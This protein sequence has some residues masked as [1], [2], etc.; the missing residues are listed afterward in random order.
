M[1]DFLDEHIEEIIKNEP[2]IDEIIRKEMEKE[3]EKDKHYFRIIAVRVLGACAPRIRRALKEETT[4]FLCNDYEDKYD[5]TGKWQTIVKITEDGRLPMDFFAIPK[6][7]KRFCSPSV[8]ISAIVGKNGD[9]KSSLVEVMLRIINNF[10][11]AFGFKEDQESLTSIEGL[12]AALFYEIDEKLYFIKC[13]EGEVFVS[14]TEEVGKEILKKHEEALF[15]TIVANYSIYAYNSRHFKQDNEDDE[16][17]WINGVFHKNDS[18]QTPMV[19][20]PMRTEGNFDVN[21][22][23]DLCCQRLMSIYADLGDDSDA[24]VINERKIATG[25][26]FNLEEQ[27]KLETTTLRRYFQKTWKSTNLNSFAV[28]LEEQIEVIKTSKRPPLKELVLLEY[29]CQVDFWAKYGALWKK[30]EGLFKLANQVSKQI[31][32]DNQAD[33]NDGRSDLKRYIGAAKEAFELFVDDRVKRQNAIRSIEW[34]EGECGMLTGLQLQRLVLVID[35]CEKWT[36]HEWFNKKD[37]SLAIKQYVNGQGGKSI[38]RRQAFLYVIYKTISIFTQYKRFQ[39]LLDLENRKFYLFDKQFDDGS[40]YYTQLSLCFN[41]LFEDEKQNHIEKKYDTLKLRQTINYL[42][43]QSFKPSGTEDGYTERD[44]GYR[45]YVT[46]DKLQG[47]ILDAKARCNEE[48]IA[49]LPPPIFVGDILI[50]EGENHP[51][52]PRFKMS[53]LSS[54]EL[55]MLNSVSTYIYHLRNLNYHVGSSTFVE[56]SYVNLVLEEVELYFHPEYQR[57]YIYYMLKQ[58]EQARLYN[59]KAINVILVTHSPFVLT[60]IPKNNVLFL[61]KGEPV[62]VMQENTFGA[63]IHSLLQNGFFLEG[64]PMG[65]FAKEKINKMFERLHKN[66]YSEDLFEEIKLVSEPLLK[67]QLYQLYSLNKL[68]HHNLQYEALLEKIKELEE[69]VNGRY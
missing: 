67:T 51:G 32:L 38:E 30:Y 53:D 44:F 9:G 19:L 43:Y 42:I 29:Q 31:Y 1:G 55:Q 69:K 4:Y 27:S 2:I 13:T 50:R 3:L 21:R 11:V 64:A 22:E 15:Y 46:F 52:N 25:F 48:T 54:G 40:E 6:Q 45:N 33:Y 41:L 66:D 49:L 62:H 68:P 20:N 16:G 24:R 28:E 57:Q 34:M 5:E 7:A 63:N 37:F 12:E 60:D 59:I 47:F 58:I 8:S 26:A 14:F 10:G 36:E 65:E 35:V 61:Q 56:Y 17:C 23:E 18:Y 39:D